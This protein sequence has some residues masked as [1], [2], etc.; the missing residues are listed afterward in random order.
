MRRPGDKMG[1]MAIQGVIYNKVMGAAFPG[2]P[3]VG[4]R[5]SQTRLRLSSGALEGELQGPGF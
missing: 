1:Q 2:R 4:T 3:Y 5:A